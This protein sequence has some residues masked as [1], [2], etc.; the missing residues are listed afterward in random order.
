LCNDIAFLR[1]DLRHGNTAYAAKG[2]DPHPP[3]VV[4][5]FRT[6]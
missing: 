6:S 5:E 4:A 3:E 2:F 1:L